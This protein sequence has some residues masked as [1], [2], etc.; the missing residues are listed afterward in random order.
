MEYKFMSIFLLH[1]TVLVNKWLHRAVRAWL[2]IRQKGLRFFLITSTKWL[3]VTRGVATGGISVYI[4]PQSVYLKFFMWLF[5]LLDPFIPT[6]IKF[7]AAPLTVTPQ[8][9]IT[10]EK[11]QWKSIVFIGCSG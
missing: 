10:F 8:S 9:V 11:Q 5:C 6:Q 4:P 7:L 3:T 1:V 2:T